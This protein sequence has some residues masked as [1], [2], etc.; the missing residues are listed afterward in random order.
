MTNNFSEKRVNIAQYNEGYG[1]IYSRSYQPAFRG[2]FP[3]AEEAR[4]RVT[5]W[6]QYGDFKLT[7]NEE[8]LD[9]TF[10]VN[11]E[12][13]KLGLGPLESQADAEDFVPSEIVEQTSAAPGMR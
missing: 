6:N 8:V 2:T 5:E 4:G 12:R 11:V 9:F 13:A 7:L 1:V 10:D 3:S